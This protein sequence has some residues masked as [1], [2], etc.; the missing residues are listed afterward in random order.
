[1]GRLGSIW[2]SWARLGCILLCWYRLGWA[3]LEL[4]WL[5]GLSLARLGNVGYV[6]A[7][8]VWAGLVCKGRD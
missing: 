5:G 3:L 4:A 6:W 2:L 7:G 1:M 8:L